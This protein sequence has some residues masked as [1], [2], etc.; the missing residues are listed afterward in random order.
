MNIF[1]GTLHRNSLLESKEYTRYNMGKGERFLGDFLVMFLLID[2]KKKLEE[3]SILRSLKLNMYNQETIAFYSQK[4]ISICF[5]I[6]TYFL[7][8][9]LGSGLSPQSCLYFQGFWGL[10]LFNCYLIVWPITYVCDKCNNFQDSKLIFLISDSNIFTIM[11]LR[12]L[13]CGVLSV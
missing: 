11:L 7:Y 4:F 8:K 2:L 10:K 12:R 9:P 6:Y 3:E 13:N 5:M 1:N